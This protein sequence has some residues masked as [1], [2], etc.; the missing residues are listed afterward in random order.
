MKSQS[1][2][3]RVKNNTILFKIIIAS[4]VSVVLFIWNQDEKRLWIKKNV[5]SDCGG[6]FDLF[7]FFFLFHIIK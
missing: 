2:I 7:P 5:I 3:Y 6:K 1:K 4:V